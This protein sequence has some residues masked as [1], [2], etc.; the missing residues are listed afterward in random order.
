[1]DKLPQELII[2]ILGYSDCQSC[3]AMSQVS[4]EYRWIL[5]EEKLWTSFGDNY[6]GY[7]LVLSRRTLTDVKTI[8][9]R[10]EIKKTSEYFLCVSP[11]RLTGCWLYKDGQFTGGRMETV[12][13]KHEYKYC[14]CT[15]KSTHAKRS[16]EVWL[17]RGLYKL[18]NHTIK[19]ECNKIWYSYGTIIGYYPFENVT[20]DMRYCCSTVAK[21]LKFGFLP[22]KS[23]Y[24]TPDTLYKYEVKRTQTSKLE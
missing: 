19:I 13:I 10:W 3:L 1:M 5:D 8:R 4:P 16:E 12:D 14:E 22:T 6:H 24:M 2:H 11:G 7:V 23:E 18:G 20:E 15:K 9:Y 21:M 17:K